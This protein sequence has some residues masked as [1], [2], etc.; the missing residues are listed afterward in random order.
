MGIPGSLGISLRQHMQ[1]WT[2]E[3]DKPSAALE[4]LNIFRNVLFGR[5]LY[6]LILLL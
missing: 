4:K 5:V 6:S 3:T 1:R 2:V